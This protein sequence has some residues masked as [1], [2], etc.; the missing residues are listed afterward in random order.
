MK[1]KNKQA[2]GIA[3]GLVFGILVGVVTKN[4]GL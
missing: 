4:I 3:L 2:T 1:N